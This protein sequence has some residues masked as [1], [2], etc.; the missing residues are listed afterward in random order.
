MSHDNTDRLK[1]LNVQVKIL[2]LD[3]YILVVNNQIEDLKRGAISINRFL[4]SIK[5]KVEFLKYISNIN[6]SG[7]NREI[8]EIISNYIEIGGDEDLSSYVKCY[9]E[10]IS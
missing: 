2:L 10:N 1:V 5:W 8:D 9:V 6:N 7:L 4:E 3:C